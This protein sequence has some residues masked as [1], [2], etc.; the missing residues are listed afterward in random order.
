MTSNPYVKGGIRIVGDWSFSDTAEAVVGC[1][2][3]LLV[4]ALAFV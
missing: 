2:L 3:A 4:L 1:A